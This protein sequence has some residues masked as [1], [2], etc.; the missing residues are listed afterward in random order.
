MIRCWPVFRRS[1]AAGATHRAHRVGLHHAIRRA[2]RHHAV[3][4][5]FAC[6][7][8]GAAGAIGGAGALG[9]L[10]WQES[11]FAYGPEIAGGGINGGSAFGPVIPLEANSTPQ[12]VPEP[13]SLAI[14][15]VGVAFAIVARQRARWKR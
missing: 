3:L 8:F 6:T 4:V 11:G 5:G 12:N 1:A 13:S 10:P 14:F 2:V 15:A 9:W 7:V